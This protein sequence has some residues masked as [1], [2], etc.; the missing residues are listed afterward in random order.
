M[1]AKKQ[2]Q[3]KILTPEEYKKIKEEK[4]RKKH[5]RKKKK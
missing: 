5:G 4:R 1:K 2:F 3:D